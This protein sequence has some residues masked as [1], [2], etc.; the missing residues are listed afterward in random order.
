MQAEAKSKSDIAVIYPMLAQRQHLLNARFADI[1]QQVAEN[2][3]ADEYPE[4][5]E[6]IVAI[7]GNLS[8]HIS[9]FPRGK[10]ANNIEIAITG[11]QIV[12][13]NRQPGSEKFDRTQ[14]NL[15]NA[16]SDRIKDSR[17]DHLERAIG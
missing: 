13:S 10:R 6:S 8:I 2:L 3:I 17:A 1:L 15:A 5:I 11:Y 14:Y 16:Y 7:L 9:D 4:A 12:L